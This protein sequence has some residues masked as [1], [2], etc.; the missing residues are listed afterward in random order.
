VQ[1]AGGDRGLLE[2][3]G[4]LAVQLQPLAALAALAARGRLAL[5]LRHH[6]LE[7]L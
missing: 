2:Q 6:R 5:L 4:R 7:R 1:A 3:L